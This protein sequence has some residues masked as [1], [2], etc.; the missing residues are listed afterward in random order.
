MR[1]V[2]TFVQSD[3]NSLGTLLIAKDAKL[4]HADSKDKSDC[5]DAQADFSCDWEHHS[6]RRF[7]LSQCGSV[8]SLHLIQMVHYEIFQHTCMFSW[9]ST[10]MCVFMEKYGIEIPVLFPL[11]T[12]SGL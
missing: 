12:N 2:C 1:S 5:A 8:F 6:V 11:K 10:Y 9:S 3:Q 4:V 7:I